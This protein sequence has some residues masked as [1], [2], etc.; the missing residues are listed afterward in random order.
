ME[1]GDQVSVVCMRNCSKL[2]ALIKNYK[3]F[4]G[5]VFENSVDKYNVLEMLK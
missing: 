3:W 4:R 1:S 2:L 5:S